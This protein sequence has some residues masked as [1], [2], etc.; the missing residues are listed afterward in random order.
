MTIFSVRADLFHAYGQTD[1]YTDMTKVIVAFGNFAD[2]A[3]NLTHSIPILQKK[4]C[5]N[6]KDQLTKTK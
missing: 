2:A 3:N 4:S 1:E 6:Y 5:V